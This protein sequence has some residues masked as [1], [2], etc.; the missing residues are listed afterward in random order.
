[1]NAE[2]NA[3]KNLLKDAKLDLMDDKLEDAVEKVREAIDLAKVIENEN[4]LNQIMEFVQQF[5]YSP[6]KQSLQLIPIMTEGHILDIGGG[7]EGII[8]KL[9]GNQV[10]AIDKSEK[11][12]LETKNK[13]LKIVMDAVKLKFLPESFDVCTAFFSLMYIPQDDHLRVFEEVNRVLGSNGRFLIWDVK[14]PKKFGNF[15]AFLI[16][17]NVELP[18]ETVEAGYGVLWQVQSIEYFKDLAEKSDFNVV[19][20]WMKDDI[21]HLELRKI[22]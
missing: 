20:E 21:L 16:Q 9:N 2:E 7:G 3:V 14:I 18:T 11:E 4:L 6:Q 1:M 8:G 17:L 10:I 5:S 15:K 12:L 22:Q 13:A 19:N